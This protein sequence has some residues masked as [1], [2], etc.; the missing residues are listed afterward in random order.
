MLEEPRLARN[1]NTQR[2]LLTRFFLLESQSLSPLLLNPKA[3]WI[4]S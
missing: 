1:L 3:V 4:L 2:S